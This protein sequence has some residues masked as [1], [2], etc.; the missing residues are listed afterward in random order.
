MCCNGISLVKKGIIYTRK[1]HNNLI[2]A[3]FM[4][5]YQGILTAL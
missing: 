1:T 5:S 3:A 2:L 4:F